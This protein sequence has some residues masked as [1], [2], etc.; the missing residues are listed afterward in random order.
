[1]SLT[2][3]K[4]RSLKPKLRPYKVADRH[5]LFVLVSP[6]GGIAWKFNY[7]FGGKQRT[8]SLGRW[9]AVSIKA[10]RD[11]RDDAQNLLADGID[12]AAEK[13]ARKRAAKAP[14]DK[15]TFEEA[16]REWHASKRKLSPKYHAQILTRLETD[17]FPHIGCKRF[18]DITRADYVKV[19]E[20]KADTPEAAFRLRMYVTQICRYAGRAD[21]SID[22]PS[23]F[24][25]GVVDARDTVH[26]KALPAKELGALVVRIKRYDRAHATKNGEET[27]TKLALLLALYTAARTQEII[28][29]EWSEFESIDTPESALWSI[30]AARMK[31]KDPHVIPLSRQACAVLAELRERTGEGRYLFPAPFGRRGHMSNNAML[32]ALYRM[33]YRGRMTVHG[34]RRCFSTWGNENRTKAGSK[35]TE[36]DVE[37]C[38]AHDDRDKVRSAYNAAKRI[39]E[40]RALVQAWGNW[41]QREANIHRTTAPRG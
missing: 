34:M 32:F 41:L 31:M 17:V 21:D 3:S 37:L 33:G 2:E 20:R 7:V 38:L 27:E 28:G 40:R 15:P 8:L 39:D 30:P 36:E 22:D 23:P 1:M 18:A 9:P 13:Q 10:A 11:K 6:A 16:A 5:S 35:W 4:L 14:A 29:A 26:H 25:R 12:P 24:L 19:L